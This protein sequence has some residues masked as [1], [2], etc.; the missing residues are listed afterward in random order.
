[1]GGANNLLPT[2]GVMLKGVDVGDVWPN[3][4]L[5]NGGVTICTI[6]A[7]LDELVSRIGV[8]VQQ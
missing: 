2:E 5:E 3:H 4:R 1:M 6:W 8:A 7:E